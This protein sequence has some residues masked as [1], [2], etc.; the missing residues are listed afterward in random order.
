[1]KLSKV[2]QDLGKRNIL[3]ITT[4]MVA[5]IA[6]VIFFL[7]DILPNPYFGSIL[8]LIVILGAWS[9]HRATHS[10]KSESSTG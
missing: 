10:H 6:G 9:I 3:I 8:A 7:P 5:S 4:I 2:W 1:M